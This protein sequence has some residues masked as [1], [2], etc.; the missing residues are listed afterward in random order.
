MSTQPEPEPIQEWY[1]IAQF[2]DAA[3][4]VCGPHGDYAISMVKTLADASARAIRLFDPRPRTIF[5]VKIHESWGSFADRIQ[6]G[7]N[8]RLQGQTP[9]ILG[10]CKAHEDDHHV[11][12]EALV[13]RR[14]REEP[15]PPGNTA[16]YLAVSKSTGIHAVR[17]P[18]GRS[19]YREKIL[20]G[21]GTT[22]QEAEDAMHA[23]VATDLLERA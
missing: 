12:Y 5:D 1:A 21:F 22:V 16:L 6:R 4:D 8:G 18:S 3:L 10:L 15:E 19:V 2:R 17:E 11:L 7:L 23:D 13:W 9:I 20:Y 14:S